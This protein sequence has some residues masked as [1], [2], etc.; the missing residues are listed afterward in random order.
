MA[1][2]D[3]AQANGKPA[4]PLGP[5]CTTII[6]PMSDTPT[7][8]QHVANA[9]PPGAVLG[10]LQNLEDGQA[11]MR[12]WE[13]SLPDP[14]DK[15][16]RYLLLRSGD[17]VRAYV[18]RCAHFGVP[19]AQKQEQLMFKPHTSITCNVHYARYD[20]N[21]GHCL[22]GDCDGEGLLPIPVVVDM[23]GDIRIGA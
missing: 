2:L 21:D 13:G 11:L 5:L 19:L 17:C 9:P 6:P 7:H 15:P 22:G 8:W 1:A 23:Q 12:V 20:W 4:Q 18:N 3:L 10:R 14:A 16:F